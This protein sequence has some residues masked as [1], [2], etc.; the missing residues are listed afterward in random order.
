MMG[1]S[2][3]Q[4]AASLGIPVS[5]LAKAVYDGR[6]PAPAKTPSGAYS[7]EIE[8]LNRA[9]WVMLRRPFEAAEAIGQAGH[10]R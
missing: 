9:S 6:V 3:K 7:W 2:T 4:A 5:K 10:K 8:D 1:K